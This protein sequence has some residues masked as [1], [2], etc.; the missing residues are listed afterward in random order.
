M[1]SALKIG[2]LK[3]YVSDF[4]NPTTVGQEGVIVIPHL[5]ASTE[6]SEDNCA[7]MAVQELTDYME[8]GNIKN[9]VNFPAINMGVCDKAG[10]IIIFHRNKANMITKFSACFGN[11]G[12]NISEMNNK[13]RGDNAV[14]MIDFDSEISEDIIS[15]LEQIEDV[16][17]VRQI[18]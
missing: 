17:R 4:P 5:G 12:I 1:I 6:E 13:S 16:F 14:T 15:G 2:K 18:V 10:R 9:S 11:A 7:V 8:N 3:K